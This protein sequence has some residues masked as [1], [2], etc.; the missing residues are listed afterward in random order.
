[1]FLATPPVNLWPLGLVALVPV[2]V[3]SRNTGFLTTGL[4][5]GL[6]FWAA[7]LA[8]TR[9]WVPLL[10]DFGSLDRIYAVALAIL[11][12]V[13]QALP[14]LFAGAATR[15][16]ESKVRLSVLVAA[17]LCFAMAE[18]W[19]P[20]P[21]KA[22]FA[23]IVWRVWP[24]TQAA[25]IGGPAAVTGLLVL[26]NV[27]IAEAV[28]RLATRSR[29][30]RGPTVGVI[31]VLLTIGG[32]WAR[33]RFV[34]DVRHRSHK[35]K[36]GLVQPNFGPLSPKM[37]ERHGQR[38]VD[39]LVGLTRQLDAQ[40]AE[41][42]LWPESAWPFPID[43]SR[44]GDFP[45]GHPWRI[46]NGIKA[47][48]L[49]GSLTDDHA[50]GDIYN[51]ALLLRSDGGLELPYDKLQLVPFA[52]RFPFEA[53]MPE[54]AK[55]IRERLPDWPKIEQG[56]ESRIL[57]SGD[58]RIAPLLCSEELDP[59]HAAAVASRGC[60]LLVSLANDAWFSGPAAAEQHLALASFRAIENRRDMLRCTTNGI[61]AHFDPL[62]RMLGSL[63]HLPAKRDS[64]NPPDSLLA[65]AALVNVPTWAN[66]T[67]PLFPWAC[68][69][70]VS[71]LIVCRLRPGH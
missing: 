58:F 45:A 69:L 25:E 62:G 19:F 1:M 10:E 61:T 43:R 51:S 11:I 31:V 42:V 71:V 18:S 67:T 47:Q 41:L 44:R 26:I 30:W 16:L 4:C 5:W 39:C 29:S 20:F 3:M 15:M 65:E 22:H 17:P 70:L 8:V 38:V 68:L 28:V 57:A 32:A 35:T 64:M 33:A 40:G 13:W 36:T 24:L 66:R 2:F 7:I 52:E 14:Y 34:E 21:F 12:A 63:P 49:F 60:N 55:R 54:T 6:A 56:R 37:R 23:I 50:T 27:I 9:W 59:Q 53:R 48:V 46:R